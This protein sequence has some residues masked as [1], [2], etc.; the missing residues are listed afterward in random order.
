MEGK[1]AQHEHFFSA[2]ESDSSTSSRTLSEGEDAT[3]DETVVKVHDLQAEEAKSHAE[4]DDDG[5][6]DDEEDEKVKGICS[7]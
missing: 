5:S 6:D 4:D 2:C 1:E 7:E 3:T